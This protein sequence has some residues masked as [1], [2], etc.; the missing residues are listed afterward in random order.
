M[1]KQILVYIKMCDEK[2]QLPNKAGL[3]VCLNIDRST[4]SD[5]KKKFPTAIKDAENII[6]DTWVTRLTTNA[7]TGAIFYLKNAFKE[8]YK[9]RHDSDITVHAPKPLLDAISNNNGGQKAPQ[10]S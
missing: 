9:D 2:K 3:R 5:Y 7:P 8:D 10:S 1:R 4:Y 6:E